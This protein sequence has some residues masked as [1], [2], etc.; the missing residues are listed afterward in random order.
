MNFYLRFYKYYSSYKV[1]DINHY[2]HEVIDMFIYDN[3][4][5]TFVNCSSYLDYYLKSKPK[6]SLKV[7]I[8]SKLIDFIDRL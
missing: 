5:K 3:T 4:S 6:K 2:G 7:A 8:K 1:G